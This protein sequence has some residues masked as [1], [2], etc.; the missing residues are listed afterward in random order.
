ML[1]APEAPAALDGAVPSILGVLL[2]MEDRRALDS[3]QVA[4]WLHHPNRVVRRHAVLAAGRVRDRRM[5]PSVI[6][7]LADPSSSVRAE[8]AFAL[9]LMGDTSAAV[10]RALTQMLTTSADADPREGAEAA[11]SLARL[12]TP[13]AFDVLLTHVTAAAG[14]D[15]GAGEALLQLWRAPRSLRLVEAVRPHLAAPDRTV[16][17]NAAYAL[18]R[19]GGAV[20][21]PALITLANDEDPE[22][23]ALVMRALR[24][25]AVDS[26]QLRAQALPTLRAA[27]ADAHAHVRINALVSLATFRDAGDAAAIAER[28]GDANGN[29]RVAAAQALGELGGA[30]SAQRLLATATSDTI[31]IGI[32]ATALAALARVDPTAALD[33]AR[34]WARTAD[35]L[36]RLHAART[37]AALPGSLSADDMLREQA[38]D[39][40]PRIAVVALRAAAVR[41]SSAGMQALLIERLASSDAALRAAA[42]SALARNPHGAGLALLME[43]YER[44]RHDSVPAAALAVVDALGALQSTGVPAARAFFLRFPPSHDARIRRRVTERLG[45]SGWADAPATASERSDSFYVEVVRTLLVP[46]LT[47]DFRPRVAIG[48]RHGE[49]VLALAPDHAPLTVHNFLTLVNSG[50]YR[51]DDEADSS[52]TRW[53]RVVPN[54]VLQDGDPRGD[55]TGNPGYAIRDELN[56]LRYGRGVLGMALSGPDT[57]GGQYFITHAP[58]PHLDGGYT[59]FGRV[60]AGMA[61]ADSVVQDDTILYIREVR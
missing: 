57:G 6:A 59:I 38:R 34:G 28:L 53:H 1:P 9:G 56:R 49:I 8:A 32:R 60:V 15:A 40:D 55:G 43:A 30:L 29:V 61:A 52:A 37:A 31:P 51:G 58:Q 27:L 16:R 33:I 35:W 45:D 44:A 47:A 18:A 41:D 24:A 23:R 42:V 5:V 26:V 19:P 48:T 36:H 22:I 14:M 21:A 11:A 10:V 17:W 2:R 3:A 54:F 20:A 13:A 12:G 39:A 25:A 50:Y 7:A 4:T 46:A